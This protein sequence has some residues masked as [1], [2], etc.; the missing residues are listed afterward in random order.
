MDGDVWV[1]VSMGWG[2]GQGQGQLGPM[3]ECGR[4]QEGNSFDRWLFLYRL[5]QF[6]YI[7]KMYN[8]YLGAFEWRSMSLVKCKWNHRRLWGREAQRWIWYLWM[9]RMNICGPWGMAELFFLSLSQNSDRSNLGKEGFISVHDTELESVLAGK[10]GQHE[11]E[12]ACHIISTSTVR[13][14]WVINESHCSV[15]L[16]FIQSWIPAKEQCHPQ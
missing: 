11:F 10:S 16:L 12:V 8:T 15:P 7:L 4:I 9:K 3:V 6:R 1:C 2:Q 5:G 13:K 14:Q